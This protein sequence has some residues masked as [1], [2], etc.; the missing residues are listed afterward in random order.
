LHDSAAFVDVDAFSGRADGAAAASANFDDDELPVLAANEIQ[1]AE[2]AAVASRE[3]FEAVALEV[4]R[5]ARLPLAPALDMHSALAGESASVDGLRPR[6]VECHGPPA[7][8]SCERQHA[9]HAAL[10]I[11]R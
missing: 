1:L 4:R 7:L 6:Q 5:G 9:P 2:P 10:F 11:E 8:K 3:N